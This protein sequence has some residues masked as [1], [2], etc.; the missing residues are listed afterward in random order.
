MIS[1]WL[2]Q[3]WKVEPLAMSSVR[4]SYFDDATVFPAGSIEFDC[5]LLMRGIEHEWHS[6]SD[7]CCSAAKELKGSELAV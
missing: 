6:R 4:S 2:S 3:R 1:L 7:L 5:A